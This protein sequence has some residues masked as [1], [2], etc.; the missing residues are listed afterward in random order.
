MLLEG[1]GD[2]AVG[3]HEAADLSWD[4]FEH[5]LVESASRDAL[6]ELDELDNVTTNWLAH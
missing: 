2:D 4:L 1:L 5:L 3:L 6:V